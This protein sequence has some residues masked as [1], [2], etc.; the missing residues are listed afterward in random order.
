LCPAQKEAFVQQVLF[1]SKF[2]IYWLCFD[3]TRENMHFYP[4]ALTTECTI[5][6]SNDKKN[7][8]YI[9]SEK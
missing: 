1:V 6:I 7:A 3:M 5:K 4:A 9:N 8:K 2:E